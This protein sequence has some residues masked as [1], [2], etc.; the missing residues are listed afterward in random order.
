MNW[1]VCGS[2]AFRCPQLSLGLAVVPASECDLLVV[3]HGQCLSPFPPPHTHYFLFV[4]LL[5][6]LCFSS[7][8]LGSWIPVPREHSFVCSIFKQH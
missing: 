6:L 5:L 2:V 7:F 3:W 8:C 4:C 1:A